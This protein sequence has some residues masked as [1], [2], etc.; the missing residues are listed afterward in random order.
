LERQIYKP[1]TSQPDK[2]NGWDH[3]NDALG[4]GISYLFPITRQY[5]HNQTQTN[6]TVRI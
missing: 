6:W 2:D 3:M 5:T 1:G 4:Y